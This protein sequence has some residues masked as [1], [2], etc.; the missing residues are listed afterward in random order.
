M[1]RRRTIKRTAETELDSS[2][3][4]DVDFSSK[5]VAHMRI[6]MFTKRYVLE[7]TIQLMLNDVQIRAGLDTGADL[8]VMDE[9]Q[10]RSLQ[11]RSGLEWNFK[12]V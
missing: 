7:K 8:N 1:N 11:H 12:R 5:S 9:Y 10:Y 2:D 3:S 4:S 6:K